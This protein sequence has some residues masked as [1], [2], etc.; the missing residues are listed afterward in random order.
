MVGPD[1]TFSKRTYKADPDAPVDCFYVYPTVSRESTPD[2]DMTIRPEEQRVALM[3]FARFGARCKL[4]AAMYR[5]I[6][7]VGLRAA[8][9][10]AGRGNTI[11]VEQPYQDVLAAWNTYLAR[12]NHGRGVV[13]IGHSQGS[14]ILVH[15]VASQI[16]GTAKQDRLISAIRARCRVGVSICSTST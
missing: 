4:Y 14:N 3:Q 7:V 9:R 11:D 10:A 15:L 16:D 6:T 5:Q 12:Y 8:M 1:G 2:S 13:L